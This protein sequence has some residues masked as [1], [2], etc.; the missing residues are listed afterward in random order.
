MA[1]NI[2]FF[3]ILFIFQ[4]LINITIFP[5]TLIIYYGMIYTSVHI[6]NY[7]VFGSN[8][9]VKHHESINKAQYYNYG[10]DTID[11][12][13]GTNFDDSWENFGHMLPNILVS[14]I[15]CNYILKIR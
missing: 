6:I 5:N 12:I 13:F 11:H 4:K 9:H 1:T 10:P 3:F 7:S 8:H 15:I 14:Y 2:L